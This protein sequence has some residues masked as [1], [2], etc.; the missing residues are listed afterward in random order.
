MVLRSWNDAETSL[1]STLILTVKSHKNPG[2]VKTRNI[3]SSPKWKLAGL[4]VWVQSVLANAL[5]PYTHLLRDAAALVGKLKGATA[6]EGAKLMNGDIKEY[7]MSGTAQELAEDAI[8]IIE[9]D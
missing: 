3:H 4:S 9:N 2:E 6:P 5:K 8:K 1:F 7:F